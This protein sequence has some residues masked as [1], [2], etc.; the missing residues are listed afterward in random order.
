[1]KE[2]IKKYNK[3]IKILKL[4]FKLTKSKNKKIIILEKILLLKRKLNKIYNN[5]LID[6]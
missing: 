3:K 5:I 2:N 1:M 6:I 4:K